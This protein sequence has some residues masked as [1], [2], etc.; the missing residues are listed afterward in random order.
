MS[1]ITVVVVE[2]SVVIT[3]VPAERNLRPRLVVFHERPDGAP[4]RGNSFK[5]QLVE[6][7]EISFLAM[8]LLTG[9]L[10]HVHFLAETVRTITQL[11][12]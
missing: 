8:L 2:E 4:P 9:L 10:D 12:H 11:F 3:G 7:F 5:A 1:L 6:L